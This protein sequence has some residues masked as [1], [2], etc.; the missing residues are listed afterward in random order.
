MQIHIAQKDL[1]SIH[2][3]T[4]DAVNDLIKNKSD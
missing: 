1:K 2:E 4:D 3:L